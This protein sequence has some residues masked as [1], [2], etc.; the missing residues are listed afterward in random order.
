ML[1]ESF[2]M[3]LVQGKMQE[4]LFFFISSFK[5]DCKQSMIQKKYFTISGIAILLDF[6]AILR[7]VL[8]ILT[9][10]FCLLFIVVTPVFF[11]LYFFFDAKLN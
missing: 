6:F 4:T 8:E 2:N 5:D 9:E 10:V 3:L 11:Q 1:L 7:Y